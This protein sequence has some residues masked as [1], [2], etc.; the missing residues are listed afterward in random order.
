MIKKAILFLLAS[1]GIAN[2]SQAQSGGKTCGASDIYDKIKAQH[3]EVVAQNDI[4]LE[5][6]IAKYIAAQAKFLDIS[7]LMKTTAASDSLPYIEIPVVVHIIHDYTNNYV[8]DAKVAGLISNLNNYYNLKNDTTQIIKIFKKYTGNPRFRF[9]LATVDP[10]GNPTRGITRRYTYLTYGGDEK[11][12]FDLW[13]PASYMNVWVE[14]HISQSGSVVVGGVI[15]AYAHFPSAA[16]ADPYGDGLICNYNYI[17]GTDVTIPHEVGHYFSLLHPWGNTN[18]PGVSGCGD[19]FVDDT[20]PDLGLVNIGSCPLYTDTTCVRP[21][22]KIYPNVAGYDSLADYPDT[23]NVQNAMNYC[24]CS[25]FIFTKGQVNRMRGAATSTVGNRNNLSAAFNLWQTGIISPIDTPIKIFDSVTL[26]GALTFMS[27]PIL[28]P[29]AD[30]SV[31]NAAV[32]YATSQVRFFGTIYSAFSFYFLD[33]SWNNDTITSRS[34]SLSNGAGTATG[35]GTNIAS[36]FTTP[37]WVTAKLT[38]NSRVG[39]DSITKQA[40]YVADTTTINPLAASNYYAEFSPTGDLA[41]W[42]TFN[43]YNNEFK[44]QPA[45]VGYY[46]NSSI[47]YTGYDS[48]GYPANITGTPAGDFDDL[49]SPA[50]N[51]SSFNPSDICNLS[52]MY[53]GAFKTGSSNYMND[54]LDISYTT[55]GGRTWT[56]I[57]TLSKAQI[58]NNGSVGT[59]FTPSAAWQWS[60]QSINIPVVA[61]QSQVYFR[62]RYRPGDNGFGTST[63]NNFYLDRFNISN[64]PLGVNT[65]VNNS[66][67]I[68]I[69]PNPTTGSSY[70]VINNGGNGVATVNVTDITGKQVYSTRQDMSGVT[71]SIEI[72]ASAISV[73]GMYLVQVSF[74]DKESHTEKLVVY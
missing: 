50:F 74:N 12:K 5:K 53:A 57:S 42:P 70:L 54:S 10:S 3:P 72:P 15:V 38:V 47:M 26:A 65:V 11:A 16:A 20:P 39:S 24:G 14:D 61:R 29:I 34:W 22:F 64:S 13:N 55:D 67:S 68:A 4:Q 7:K 18:N 8:T 6:D 44:W 37:G 71:T 66:K 23:A 40:I 59:P 56:L 46:D 58:A 73:K 1:I 33:K 43:Y 32:G 45:N 62:F 9:H 49:F 2:M 21:Y 69:A 19:D 27:R 17:A 28:P 25:N 48:R 30:F 63:G 51:L 35:T 31:S 41:K 36:T 60:L 52:Y